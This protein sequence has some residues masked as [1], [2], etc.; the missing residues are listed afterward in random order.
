MLYKF[1]DKQI[2]AAT[3]TE[4]VAALRRD[5]MNPADNIYAY[6]EGFAQRYKL[7]TANEIRYDTPENFVADL[8]ETKYLTET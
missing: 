2:E 7:Q 6:M 8:I 3:A 1:E 4:L 5:S